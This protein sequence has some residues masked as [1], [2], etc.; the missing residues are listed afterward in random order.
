[1]WLCEKK[2]AS[3]LSFEIMLENLRKFKE[4]SKMEEKKVEVPPPP[5]N[6]QKKKTKSL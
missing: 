3:G 1:M 6:S 4:I 2:L 5:P